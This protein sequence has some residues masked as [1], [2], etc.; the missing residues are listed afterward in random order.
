MSTFFSKLGEL[1][2]NRFNNFE[3]LLKNQI[4]TVEPRFVVSS[5]KDLT[6]SVTSIKGNFIALEV[7]KLTEAEKFQ[8]VSST[9][10]TESRRQS[11]LVVKTEI[12]L[13]LLVRK[14]TKRIAQEQ[15][16]EKVTLLYNASRQLKRIKKILEYAQVEFLPL[17]DLFDAES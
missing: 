13:D 17:N 3:T 6:D 2:T 14:I 16:P 5:W 15:D 10:D 11:N 4:P 1:A 7:L 9:D 12:F 8:L